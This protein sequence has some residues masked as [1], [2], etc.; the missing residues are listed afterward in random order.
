MS[1]LSF[2]VSVF[3]R[4]IVAK[5]NVGV[6]MISSGSTAASYA[7]ARPPVGYPRICGGFVTSIKAR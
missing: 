1:G 7:A 6:A 4:L 5:E 3:I 2:L